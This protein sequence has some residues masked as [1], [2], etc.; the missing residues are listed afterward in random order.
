VH[1]C[2]IV[3]TV[4]QHFCNIFATFLQ[5]FCNLGSPGDRSSEVAKL[6]TGALQ[7]QEGPNGQQ[8]G[9]PG[10]ILVKLTRRIALLDHLPECQITG[11]S[12]SSGQEAA[13]AASGSV[14]GAG[15]GALQRTGALQ[16]PGTL[17]GQHQERC[18]VQER[19][20]VRERCWSV[21]GA[22]SG[23]LQRLGAL[24]QCCRGRIRSVAAS[25]SVT[26]A[27]QGQDQVSGARFVTLS[28]NQDRSW[29][30][31]RDVARVC[32]V[33]RVPGLLQGSDLLCYR[34]VAGA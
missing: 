21:A 28:M 12:S 22:G 18:S 1:F 34:D 8:A 31:I 17:Q 25:G 6:G 9:Q 3:A 29:G 7:R 32:Y 20:S 33:D 24:Q 19:Y 30:R 2:N 27:L 23:A 4:L 10:R 13:V 15:S 26:G 5:H 16:R 14:A 11:P